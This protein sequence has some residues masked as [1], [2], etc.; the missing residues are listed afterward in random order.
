MAYT[1]INSQPN[2]DLFANNSKTNGG[3]ATDL[4][5]AARK[6]RGSSLQL[7]TVSGDR[8]HLLQEFG[9]RTNRLQFF[10]PQA[11]QFFLTEPTF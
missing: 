4:Q 10:F 11:A 8:I 9:V 1:S 6:A 5:N 7:Q 2:D 3:N